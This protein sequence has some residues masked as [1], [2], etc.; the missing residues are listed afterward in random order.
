MAQDIRF[1]QKHRDFLAI[2]K[3]F[4]GN[5]TKAIEKAGID[6][7][8]YNGWLRI[9]TFKE[10]VEWIRDE[11]NDEIEARQRE[12]ALGGGDKPTT[13]NVIALTNYLRA[14]MPAKYNEKISARVINS[15]EFSMKDIASIGKDPR[16]SER[17]FL[18][19][20]GDDHNNELRK[21]EKKRKAE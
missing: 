14:N 4:K 1:T 12:V 13:A 20:I 5:V 21:Q 2:L 3:E 16:K 10:R 9:E 6:R 18:A 8:M 19:K 17:G 7:G 15:G 11:V